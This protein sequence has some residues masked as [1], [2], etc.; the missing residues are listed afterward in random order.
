MSSDAGDVFAWL[1]PLNESAREAFN[2]TVNGV[3][4]HPT[5][6][7]HMRQFLHCD[8]RNKRA[9]S[10]FSEDGEH[11]GDS[12]CVESAYQWNGAFKLSL[13][14]LPRDPSKGWVLGTNRGRPSEEG[15][16]LLLAPPTKVWATLRIAG[17]HAR[18][19]I[20]EESCRIV[21]D[22]QHTV[23]L[24]RNGAT[25]SNR[26]A[27]YSLEDGELIVIGDCAYTF[28]YSPTFNTPSFEQD[29]VRYMRD[30]C[31]PQ[32]TIHKLLTPSSVGNPISL[33]NYHL[34]PSAFAQGTFGK[35]SAGWDGNG[36]AVA[37]KSFKNPK[38]SEIKAHIELMKYI[39][40]H[41]RPEIN[42]YDN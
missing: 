12:D 9:P 19:F 23:T 16:D 29:L 3:I 31:N 1:R 18:L 14:T 7:C 4:R 42:Y 26:S 8:S 39:G 2:A 30:H 17:R 21:V 15:I 5:K 28:Q 35:V 41:V 37:I 27:P 33:G 36:A 38:A 10:L 13:R 22:A 34:S 11:V 6:F 25:I 40:D 20:H 24:G 32:W